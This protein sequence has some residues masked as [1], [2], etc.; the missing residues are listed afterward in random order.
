[1]K[2]EG[3]NAFNNLKSKAV[4]KLKQSSGQVG[5]GFEASM[6]VG[7]SQLQVQHLQKGTNKTVRRRR[8]RHHS[9][10]VTTVAGRR[11]G[12]RGRRPRKLGTANNP[13][14]SRKRQIGTGRRRRKASRRRKT[15]KTTKRRRS[16]KL[17]QLDIFN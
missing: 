7:L 5:K 2:E 14:L 17:R 6:P 9:K 10:K 11:R 15:A 8:R 4:N 13:I 1:M 16:K 12:K 3:E